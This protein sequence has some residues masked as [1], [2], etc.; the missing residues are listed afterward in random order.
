MPRKEPVRPSKVP[1]S[2]TAWL[3]SRATATG[4]RLPP[5]CEPLVGSNG[6][7]PARLG[8]DGW[9]Y[10]E[11]LPY[12][13]RLETYEGGESAYHGGNGELG[14][15]NLRNDHPYCAAWVA[16]AQQFGLPYNPDFN[17]ASTYG[18]GADLLLRVAN[19][20]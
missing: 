15:A 11:V 13:K 3:G 14:V 18:A 5:P 7:Q 12:F 6:S 8:A 4:T 16:A 1:E 17:G 2:G 19:Q 9:N 10:R 20:G